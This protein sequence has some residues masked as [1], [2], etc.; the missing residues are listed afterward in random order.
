MGRARQLGQFPANT[1][2]RRQKERTGLNN[3]MV[4]KKKRRLARTATERDGSQASATKRETNKNAQKITS[5]N[6]KGPMGEKYAGRKKRDRRVR[7][8]PTFKTKVERGTALVRGGWVYMPG[9]RPATH[10]K[11]WQRQRGKTAMI[12]LMIGREGTCS[13]EREMGS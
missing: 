3:V 6:S 7:T 12:G 8:L 2:P 13:S 4:C 9:N 5:S 11:D 10:Q 1:Q